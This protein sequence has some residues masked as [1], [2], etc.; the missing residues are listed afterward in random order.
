MANTPVAREQ[1]VPDKL[2]LW[3]IA[4]G[5]GLLLI[6]IG[7][8]HYWLRDL[9]FDDAWI[10]FRY[11]ENIARGNGFVFNEGERVLGSGGVLWNLVLAGLAL[12]VPAQTLS[13]G[14]SAL[15][16]LALLGCVLALWLALKRA[17]PSWLALLITGAVVAHGPLL[18]S[19]IGGMETVFLCLLYFLSFW[20]LARERY[21]LAGV[22]AGAAFCFR[23][24][25]MAFMAA[26]WLATWLYR[27]RDA[28]R[29][30]AASMLLPL[31]VYSWTWIYFGSPIANSTRAKSIVYVVPPLY[32]LSSC[33]DALLQVLPFNLA[34]PVW[35]YP[36]SARMFGFLVWLEF[37]ALGFYM[38]RRK[39]P[40]ASLVAIQVVASLVFYTVTNP[41]MFPWY[42]CT[43][44]PLGTVLAIL[45]MVA[46]GELIAAR[47]PWLRYGLAIALLLSFS[48][49]PLRAM[50]TPLRPPSSP[51]FSADHPN[52]RESARI[53]QYANVARW[54]NRHT[55]AADTVCISE[56]GAFGYH[57]KG[58]ILDGLGL[59]SP[60][61]LPYHPVPSP[62][63]RNG[64][65]GAIPPRAVRDFRPEFVVSMDIFGEAV[66]ADPWF[67]QNY[68]LIGRWP[69]F[70]GP[71]R[72]HNTL[73]Q[74]WGSSELFAY[75]RRDIPWNPANSSP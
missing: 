15:N 55:K 39:L 59:V 74:L 50:W 43:F 27:R 30:L 47:P 28:W 12:I 40:A 20:A 75:R 34:F 42:Y 54:L 44:V 62:L 18:V 25:S 45:G 51:E 16:Y 64:L 1:A 19:S 14:V 11:S 7:I 17:I 35:S 57:Y 3:A 13:M 46:L 72:W 37:V 70:G 24:E 73:T 32:A 48:L 66:F 61:I 41:L 56:V 52:A 53:Y 38:L 22:F 33:V 49:P 36:E 69:W 2:L 4:T 67:R 60:E 68:E 29:V 71:V 63:R 8:E 58:R 23:V 21:T 9:K 10:H 26:T 65:Y 6:L 5:L 31:L